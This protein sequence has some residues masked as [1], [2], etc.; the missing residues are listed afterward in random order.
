MPKTNITLQFLKKIGSGIVGFSIKSCADSNDDVKNFCKT[1]S[2]AIIKNNAQISI[3][4]NQLIFI[5]TT[6]K[7]LKLSVICRPRDLIKINQLFFMKKN[8]V[9]VFPL[10]EP[11]F[12]LIINEVT[13]T[14]QTIKASMIQH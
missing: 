7:I 4:D 14:K 3:I 5:N 9:T 1:F 8:G 13:K 11:G 6:S 10:K 12:G 2:D